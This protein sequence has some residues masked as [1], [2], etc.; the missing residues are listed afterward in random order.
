M[1]WICDGKSAAVLIYDEAGRLLAHTRATAPAGIALGPAG[2][3]D[4]VHPGATHTDAAVC[5]TQEEFGLTVIPDGLHLVLHRWLPNGCGADMP[6]LPNGAHWG[7]VYRARARSG[8]P[9]AGPLVVPGL[10]WAA[11]DVV[12]GLHWCTP[13]QLQHLADRTIAYVRG[14]LAEEDWQSCPGME[15]VWVYMAEM[16][17][18]IC[19]PDPVDLAAVLDY[20]R[21][22]S[23]PV[24]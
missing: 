12:H 7:M 5:E 11:S 24:R 1:T 10:H 8:H 21:A 18:L 3:V 9:F 23:A 19:V 15:P 13:A 16:L 20:A 6:A 14:R 4:D 22:G 17:H 2:H